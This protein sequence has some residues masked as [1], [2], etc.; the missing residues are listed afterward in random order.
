MAIDIEMIVLVSLIAA[1]FIPFF[2][3]SNLFLGILVY[4][5]KTMII[6]F[7]LALIRSIM[8]RIRIEQMVNFCWKFLAPVAI[9]QILIDIIVKGVLL[10]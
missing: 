1:I 4:V 7:I 9:L 2:T 6:V 5:V 8:A 3:Q 10:K